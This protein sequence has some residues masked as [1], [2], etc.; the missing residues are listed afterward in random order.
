MNINSLTAHID[1]L[2]VL[3]ADR[4]ID[5]LAINETKIDGKVS[6]NEV[7]ISGY[8]ITRSDRFY[9]GGSGGGVCFYVRSEIDYSVRNDLNSQLLENLSIEIR[10]PRSKPS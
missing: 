3:L 7:K 1:E 9:K 2:R 4:P 8:D 5:V 6:D 10:K